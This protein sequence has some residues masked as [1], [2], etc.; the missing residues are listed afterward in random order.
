MSWDVGLSSSPSSTSHFTHQDP[1]GLWWNQ[2]SPTFCWGPGR[3]ITYLRVKTYRKKKSKY[4]KSFQ[5]LMT[6][7]ELLD[8]TRSRLWIWRRWF[9]LFPV[10]GSQSRTQQLVLS[11]PLRLG[12]WLRLNLFSGSRVKESQF[13]DP[14]VELP[15]K[16][17]LPFPFCF[18]PG[19]FSGASAHMRLA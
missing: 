16:E 13:W 4:R 6:L 5:V 1:L 12:T 19:K 14:C 15:G 9:L 17:I 10:R 8:G 11:D 3:D 7:F 18:H 2:T